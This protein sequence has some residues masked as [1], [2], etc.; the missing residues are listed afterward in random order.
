M[1]LVVCYNK[2]ELVATGNISA[3]A[4]EKSSAVATGKVLETGCF[5]SN[6][7]AKLLQSLTTW[8]EILEIK[9]NIKFFR[10]NERW[11]VDEKISRTISHLGVFRLLCS[12]LLM[13]S[14]N[15]IWLANLLLHFLHQYLRSWMMIYL[16]MVWGKERKTFFLPQTKIEAN[17]I[18]NPY[19]CFLSH[20]NFSTFF[21]VTTSMSSTTWNIFTKRL[22]SRIWSLISFP[23]SPFFYNSTF[24]VFLPLDWTHPAQVQLAPHVVGG[25]ALNLWPLGQKQW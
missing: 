20:S 19:P 17:K 23:N 14:T 1:C 24:F 16:Q 13:W 22:F 3:V 9:K 18:L 11:N 5:G 15:F 10:Q 12:G 7:R 25:E 8:I 21:R 6:P 2:E 4:T